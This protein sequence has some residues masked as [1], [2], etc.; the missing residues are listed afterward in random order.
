MN[1]IGDFFQKPGTYELTVTASGKKT[2]TVTRK[3]AVTW[4]GNI[5]ELTASL[6]NA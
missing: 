2:R 5:A 6:V 1:Y 4:N 3:I